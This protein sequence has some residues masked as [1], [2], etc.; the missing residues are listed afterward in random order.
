MLPSR[1]DPLAVRRARFAEPRDRGG[2]PVD[3][4]KDSQRLSP[5]PLPTLMGLLHVPAKD[6]TL[7]L[8]DAKR[9][10][11]ALLDAFASL[12]KSFKVYAHTRS[13][14]ACL[15]GD[16]KSNG[17]PARRYLSAMAG[18]GVA[19]SPLTGETKLPSEPTDGLCRFDRRRLAQDTR[20]GNDL[21]KAP[22][23]RL[24]SGQ[25]SLLLGMPLG[26]RQRLSR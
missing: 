4:G 25:A 16:R 26:Q 24:L 21:R 12:Q 19:S 6:L 17:R 10:G 11:D 13:P 9:L 5:T 2:K 1:G 7:E 18:K 8:V 14:K 15:R 3:F 22:A 23:L 20:S